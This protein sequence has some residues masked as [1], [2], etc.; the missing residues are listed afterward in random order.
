MKNILLKLTAAFILFSFGAV[1]KGKESIPTWS[2]T[3]SGVDKTLKRTEAVYVFNFTAS[4]DGTVK[5]EIKFS[6]NGINKTERPDASGN[7][8]LKVKPGKYRFQFF[9]TQDYFEITTDSIQI[10]PAYRT[11]IAVFFKSSIIPMIE[12][13]PVIYVY[14]EK[15]MPV[16]IT[17]DLKGKL[18]FT[19]PAYNKGWNVIADPDGTIHVNDKKYN[20]LFWEGTSELAAAKINWNE[21]FIVNKN[22]LVS[23]FEEKLSQ[24]GL[25]STEIQ[26]YITYW[27][28]RMMANESNYVHFM[29]NEEFG[30][31]AKLN[32][33]PKPDVLFRV[34]MIWS[35]AGREEKLNLKEQTIPSFNRKGF[36]VVE[37][38]GAEM[39]EFEEIN[40]T[41]R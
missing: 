19:Y 12:D 3:K 30:E 27:C 13:K 39:A 26:D 20:Y 10:K 4:A 38:G 34:F 32:I 41:S 37:W 18:N 11:E 2:V 1:A 16:N 40:L 7:I 23:F 22:N 21:G 17:L 25:K 8:T 14:P 31:Y 33:T 28:P 24:M 15:T 9:F 29:F 36:S 5:K 6:C 35:K